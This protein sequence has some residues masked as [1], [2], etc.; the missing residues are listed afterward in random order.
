MR[1]GVLC[2][3]FDAMKI[4]RNFYSVKEHEYMILNEEISKL[5]KIM[6]KKM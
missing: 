5:K 6:T 4:Y 3:I 1:Y 2:L